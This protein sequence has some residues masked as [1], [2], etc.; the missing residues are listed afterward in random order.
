MI[1][2]LIAVVAVLALAGCNVEPRPSQSSKAPV[3]APAYVVAIPIPAPRPLP[4]SNAPRPIA[5]AV[6]QLVRDFPGTAGVAVRAVDEGWTVQ[7]NGRQ[8]MPQ[9][10]V[11]KLWVAMTVLDQRDQGRLRLDDPVTITPADLTVFHQPIA[12]LVKGGTFQTTVG[13]LLFRALTQSDNTANDRLLRVV[14][15]PSAVRAF[16]ERKQ[17]G[18]IR[19]GPGERLLQ[20]G[21]AGL[22]WQQSMSVGNTFSIMR[23]RLSPEVRSAAMQA[24]IADPPDGAAPL[25][26][27]DALARLARGELLS[28]TSTR[29]IIST[30]ESSRTGRA[31][32]KAGVAPGWTLAHKTG[33]GQELGRRNAGFNDVGLLTA[34]DGRRYAVAVMI[35]D[36]MRPMRDRQ[37]LIQSVAATIT[38]YR[39]PATLTSAGE[40]GEVGN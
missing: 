20:A 15:G 16:I 24:Y 25:A 17:L 13:N 33:T 36:T 23:S 4:A 18:D 27:A 22:T 6:Q 21:T 9:Q 11:S 30:M 38:G 39:G 1:G 26:I 40:D 8:R 3:Q 34:P 32:L 28:E 7:A 12:Y 14:G 10:S 31:R 35:G 29:L 19:F 2:R 5:L 37:Q